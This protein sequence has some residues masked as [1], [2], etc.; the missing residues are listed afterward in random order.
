MCCLSCCQA[1]IA[2]SKTIEGIQQFP[3]RS[4][5]AALEVIPRTLIENCGGNPIKLLTAVRAKHNAALTAGE[6]CTWGIDGNKGELADM[7]ELQ[8]W[9]PFMV[10]AQTIKTS[11]ESAC[12]LLRI[13]DI[14]SG[15]SGRGGAGGQQQQGQ[16][17]EGDDE[18]VQ[19][20]TQHKL[21]DTSAALQS[22]GWEANFVL[23]AVSVLDLPFID[24]RRPA[25]WLKLP[26]E[27]THHHC[28]ARGANKTRTTRRLQGCPPPACLFLL[29]FLYSRPLVIYDEASNI[30]KISDSVSSSARKGTR[31]RAACGAHR[32]KLKLAVCRTSRTRDEAWRC[33]R[34]TCR[35]A[36]WWETACEPQRW[37]TRQLLQQQRKSGSGLEEWSQTPQQQA[38]PQETL[39]RRRQQQRVCAARCSVLCP[40]IRALV[41]RRVC[42]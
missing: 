9:E 18:A 4:V 15:M 42:G 3:F 24:V 7:K 11:I 14:V 39:Q 16:A 8:I 30:L 31:S 12:M 29:V 26:A 25:R 22:C 38:Q 23:C 28:S 20:H 17:P 36:T 27:H 6:A 32:R 21:H 1:L 41:P 10:K 40:R 13:D 35:T 19:T 37:A 33:R 5:A 2:K 34:C